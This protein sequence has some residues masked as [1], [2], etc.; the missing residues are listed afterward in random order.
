MYGSMGLPAPAIAGG[1]LLFGA[2]HVSSLMLAAV[3]FLMLLAMV[4]IVVR[5]MS[6]RAADQR[7]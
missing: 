7:P 4:Y 3:A 6:R 1:G 2:I 5:T